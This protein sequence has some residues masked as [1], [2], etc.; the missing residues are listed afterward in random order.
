M[1]G[2]AKTTKPVMNIA[3]LPLQERGNGKTFS[4]RIGRAGP[5]LGLAALG[6][7]LHVVP[8][9]KRAFPFH[10]HHVADELF[11][12]LSGDGEYRFG[13][14]TYPVRAGDVVAAPAG[15]EAHQLINTGTEDLRYL[16]ISTIGGVDIVDYPDSGKIGVGAGIKNADFATATIRGMGRLQPAD[17]FDGEE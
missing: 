8:P 15:T 6:C 3:D 5:L 2:A 10:R 12:V 14:A 11:Y 13:D 16:G 17:Y 7:S 1:N 9:G 4:V